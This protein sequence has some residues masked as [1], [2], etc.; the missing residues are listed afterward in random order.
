M[1]EELHVGFHL[2]TDADCEYS[3]FRLMRMVILRKYSNTRV[4]M[5]GSVI[6]NVVRTTHRTLPMQGNLVVRR[7]V[8]SV[9]L[10]FFFCNKLQTVK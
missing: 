9:Q 6:H 1:L 4:G 3:G 7:P 10:Y 5:L 8:Y 2:E